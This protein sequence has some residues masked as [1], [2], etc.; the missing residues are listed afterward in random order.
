M[1]GFVTKDPRPVSDEELE[2]AHDKLRLQVLAN[3]I[4]TD[5]L[6]PLTIIIFHSI[7]RQV[8]LRFASL[9]K[10]FRSIDKD[11]SGKIDASEAMKLMK[12][13]NLTNVYRPAAEPP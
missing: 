12:T 6:P 10:A 5:N 9:R 4:A 13:Y 8:Q 11:K 7:V 2:K 1:A 3:P